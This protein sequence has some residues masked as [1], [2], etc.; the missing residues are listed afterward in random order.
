M[1]A[2]L[3][4]LI[5]HCGIDDH[6]WDIF[7]Q[8]HDLSE[9]AARHLLRA[10]GI[11]VTDESSA[12]AAL[13]EQVDAQWRL[14]LPP[15]RVARS[16]ERPLRID[17][18]LPEAELGGAF[19]WILRRE[20]GGEQR[21][22][23]PL[24]QLPVEQRREVDG[25][26]YVQ[27]G[28]DFGD[29]PELGYHRFELRRSGEEEPWATM[30]L[31]VTPPSCYVPPRLA[32]RAGV[33]GPSIQLYALRSPRNWGIGDFT[34]LRELLSL[35]ADRGSGILGLNP[36][37]A[38]FP[39][40]PERASP[41]SPASRR[42]L[43]WLYIDVEAVPEFSHCQAARALVADPAFQ[44]RL[45]TL[46][47]QER[48][49]YAG[50]AAVKQRALELL[51]EHFRREHLAAESDRGRAFRAYRADRGHPL[52]HCA[53]FQALAEHHADE[54]AARWSWPAWPDA[55]RDPESEAV[56]R[57]AEKHRARIE[58]YQYV[59]WLAESQLAAAGRHSW[60]LG[61]EVG[62]YADL[63]VGVDAGGAETWGQQ[64]LYAL[65]T[66]IG[67][68]PDD[69]NLKG[70][71]WGLPPI[72][73]A[74]LRD[75]AYAPFIDVLRAN[76][77]HGGALR[78]D[79]VMGLMRLFWVPEGA[80]PL[81]GAYVRYPFAD[82]LGILALESHRNRCLVIGEDLGTVPDEVR[83]ALGPAG[84][85]SYRVFFFERQEGGELRAPEEYPAQAVVTAST[86]DLPTLAGYWRGRDI[87]VREA[88]DLYPSPE[89]HE[90]QLVARAQDRAQILLALSRA[91][92]L[93][94]GT[95]LDTAFH[96]D[97][98]P[99]LSEAIHHYLARSPSWLLLF[100]LEDVLGQTEQVNLP[101]TTDQY[102]NWRRKLTV[103]L[104]TLAADARFARL[105]ERLQK[106]RGSGLV[107]P[108]DRAREERRRGRARHPA[109]TYRLQ[110]SCAFTFDH[111]AAL[112]PYLKRLGISHV[113]LSPVLQARPG[114]THGYDITDHGALNAEVGGREGFERLVAALHEAGLG[115]ILDMV[116]NH[117]AVGSDNPWWMDVLEHGPASR[118]A[119]FF[120]I[121]WHPVKRELHGKVLLPVL[122]DH[123]GTV[124]ERG[125]LRLRFDA[126]RGELQLA[127]HEHRFPLDPRTYPLVLAHDLRRLQQ[128]L[129]AQAPQYLE[130]QSTVAAFESLPRREESAAERVAI[131]YRDGQVLK[132][133]LARQCRETPEI[134]RF[135]EENRV[136][137]DGN[138]EGSPAIDHLHAVLEA[139]AYRLAYW[140]VA[141]DEIN[142]RRFFDINEMAGLRMENREAFEE[143]HGL[144]CAL[145]NRGAVD[146]L[147]IDHP[148]GLYD[149]EGYARAL[150]EAAD[151]ELPASVREASPPPYLVFEK[152]LAPQ[153]RLPESWP[154]R[155]TTGYDFAREV[156]GLFVDPAGERGLDQCYTWLLG[157]R[158][159]F[160][161]LLY[162]SKKRVIEEPMASEL[163]MLATELGRISELDL[164]TRDFTLKR[165]R[166][167]LSEVV[168]ALTVY[169]TYVRSDRV[170]DA[171]R[172]SISRAIARARRR[173]R[174][175][176]DSIYDFLERVLLVE[177]P[178]GASQ[179]YADAVRRFALRFQQYTG[180][181]M[182]K[183]MEDTSLYIYNRL[184]SLNEVGGD[185]R[186]FGVSPAEF[187]QRN[188][189]RAAQWPLTMLSTSTH[190][191]KRSADLR[192]RLH[193][194][195][196]VPD[197][198]R[199]AV[200]AWMQVNRTKKR[201]IG[202]TL[203]PD[204]NDE[205]A[206]YQTLIGLWP[207]GEVSAEAID[208]LRERL[209][210]YAI[211]AAREAK[212]HTQW[213]HVDEA[214]ERAL[215]EFTRALL[216]DGAPD[217]FLA[218]FRPLQR[219]VAHFGMLNG[220]SEMLL[221]LTSPGVPD[222]YQGTE[223]WRRNLVDPDN[224]RPVDYERRAVMLDA[225]DPQVGPEM[226]RGLLEAL[227]DGRAKL[228][229]IRQ[230]LALRGARHELF[231]SGDYVP[232]EPRGA[233]AS[234]L[235]A[236]ARRSAEATVL[237][238]APRLYARLVGFESGALPLGDAVWEDSWIPAPFGS[239]G[240]T[241][242]NVLTAETVAFETIDGE[243]ALRVSALCRN[244][245]VACLEST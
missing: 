150:L 107:H 87:A 96:P 187:H 133:Q 206:L 110:M 151:R 245:P 148:D 54:D 82:L 15:V 159:D 243:V 171:D 76:M 111:A 225:L 65:S 83:E 152:I 3:A 14:P 191:S 113:Y 5:A 221:T 174:A 233:H 17:L 115:L 36:L 232:L 138:G 143:T 11:E 135:I 136:F 144:V 202:N 46:R 207:A 124:L 129:G 184:I 47:E 108:S 134:V 122:E 101:G 79:H 157:R 201:R 94:E 147:R 239:A 167:A 39:H 142:Y 231:R 193:V 102:P 228:L 31:I 58:F 216:A 208:Q 127:Y 29:L 48:V 185:P 179:A 74:R 197:R 229:L 53:L 71:D 164:H 160:G 205:Y 149:S 162:R 20:Q 244:F 78:I 70:Q 90:A 9:E 2:A 199:T 21:G 183:G 97:M 59:Q 27:V 194:L 12:A 215:R 189:D 73:P 25:R 176:D 22:E 116:P 220:L 125:L 180:P 234:H 242:R 118:R 236:F 32:T 81:E 218:G 100:Q 178:D 49:D 227:D 230:I 117:M 238:V 86:H 168:A 80:T 212:V 56:A 88:L 109:A 214:Y 19:E 222:I 165:M 200:R 26:P 137:F 10:M 169:R 119:A 4:E 112:V 62:L 61:L 158:R 121:D 66:R 204:K 98:T 72:V 55:H 18:H 1:N 23:V 99:Q 173:D 85:L 52:W 126:E 195:S 130:F 170:T 77:R 114:S 7:G 240:E 188:A 226:A 50:V 198:W 64:D 211:K 38:L 175:P 6:Y 57:F 190:D 235:V 91:E 163:N 33:W 161:E 145:V 41:Y 219:R 30:S 42:F 103:D 177:T 13:R 128:A 37:H 69:L 223:L 120:D 60:E 154:V 44:A 34:D 209:E 181:V 224:R 166:E 104:E 84:V 45:R 203:A 141:S 213:I 192:A 43:N 146:G 106:E 95:S 63:A 89:V 16:G 139:Q 131:R 51:Y 241:L 8:R 196:E 182:A 210:G 186:H 28:F 105:T 68:P 172:R 75:R 92:L 35:C 140:R 93:P 155:G 132:R 123:Y 156:G 24:G 153:E 40:D 217:G 237:V 67:A